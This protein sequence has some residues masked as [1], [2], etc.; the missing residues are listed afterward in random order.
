MAATPILDLEVP[1]PTRKVGVRSRVVGFLIGVVGGLGVM[2][3]LHDSGAPP[4]GLMTFLLALAL[5]VV[6]HELGHLIAGWAVGF[7]FNAVQIGWLFL[8]FEYGK[9][10]FA[11]K[12]R[13]LLGYASVQ[14][15][16]IRQLRLRLLIFSTGGERAKSTGWQAAVASSPG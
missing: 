8:G 11:T 13:S 14:I 3:F 9:L 1:L 6:V 15:D 4:A 16:R 7:H 12:R 2:V 10:T 5:V